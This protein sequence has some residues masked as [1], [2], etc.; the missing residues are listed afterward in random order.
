[1]PASLRTGGG[2]ILRGRRECIWLR[3]YLLFFFTAGDNADEAGK[4]EGEGN[5][6]LHGELPFCQTRE[7]GVTF[8]PRKHKANYLFGSAGRLGWPASDVRW[9]LREGAGFFSQAATATMHA[10][11]KSTQTARMGEQFFELRNGEAHSPSAF[12]K[13]CDAKCFIPA[14]RTFPAFFWR[15]RENQRC[16]ICFAVN[17]LH[18]QSNKE[19]GGNKPA[20]KR[21]SSFE[22]DMGRVGR[23]A[24]V[25]ELVERHYE[26]VYRYAFRLAGAASDAED[27]TQEAFVKAQEKL[28][29]LRETATARAW[30]LSIARNAFLQKYRRDQ[31]ARELPLE[32]LAELCD[33]PEEQSWALEEIDAEKLQE[34]L[35]ELP[36]EFRTPLVLY[37]FDDCSYKD[38]A[39]QM[40]VPIGTVMSRLARA[41]GHLRKRL[42]P[43]RPA[44][45]APAVIPR[46]H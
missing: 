45:A 33:E 44:V 34:A 24:A 15:I 20:P 41:K 38:I 10:T 46:V 43:S 31:R 19:T 16:L 35:A 11:T 12:S 18:L 40:D 29:Q 17:V 23:A 39:Q 22:A 8:T 6:L 13:D 21:I 1:M 27:L 5:K 3:R 25:S 14:T 36:E 26:V 42:S 4:H 32:S 9:L 37:Y 28:D 7:I 2:G 30:L